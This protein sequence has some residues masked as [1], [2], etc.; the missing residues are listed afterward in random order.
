[1]FVFH[2]MI[3]STKLDLFWPTIIIGQNLANCNIHAEW[4]ILVMNNMKWYEI[5]SKPKVW[6]KKTFVIYCQAS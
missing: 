4:K 3:F 6:V 5:W 2:K 1:M